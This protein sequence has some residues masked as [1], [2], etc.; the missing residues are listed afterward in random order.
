MLH[1]LLQHQHNRI[2]N[3]DK[4]YALPSFA[5][6]PTNEVARTEYGVVPEPGVELAKQ[7]LKMAKWANG[8]RQ[9]TCMLPL[10]CP[11]CA[12]KQ[13]GDV[14]MLDGQLRFTGK[15]EVV[16]LIHRLIATSTR[17]G[18]RVW[19][20]SGMLKPPCLESF[21]TLNTAV[22]AYNAFWCFAM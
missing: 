1:R 2:Y 10:C 20:R 15:S 6:A 18:Q 11:D 12:L 5:S 3:H 19:Y 21:L 7:F 8:G 22:E 4:K 14:L 17:D 13:C 16:K 9:Y